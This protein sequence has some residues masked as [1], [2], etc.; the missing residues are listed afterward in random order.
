MTFGSIFL[1]AKVSQYRRE[2]K[3]FSKVKD[4]KS[5]L[6]YINLITTIFQKEKNGKNI[7]NKMEY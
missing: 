6:E 7:A 5:N 2:G 4:A 1:T 3:S